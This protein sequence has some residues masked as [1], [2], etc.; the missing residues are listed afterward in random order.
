M[1]SKSRTSTPKSLRYALA[2][3]QRPL[4]A[5]FLLVATACSLVVSTSGLTGRA[6]PVAD[7]G[8]FGDGA[9]SNEGS[10]DSGASYR[11]LVLSD[12]PIAYWR[13]G[14]DAGPTLRDE[15]PAANGAKVS[16]SVTLGAPGAIVGESDTAASFTAAGALE[17]ESP[18][19]FSGVQPWTFEV[20][21]R[22]GQPDDKFRHLMS[23]EGTSDAGRETFGVYYHSGDVIV[24]RWVDGAG[25]G[26]SATP[27]AA[28]RWYHFVGVYDGTQ[29]IAYLDGSKTDTTPDVRVQRAKPGVAF[30][31]GMKVLPSTGGL[32]G[33]LDEVAVY[34]KALPAAAI[35]RHY[36]IGAGK[37]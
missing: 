33:S 12:G 4:L 22:P 31:V 2:V 10:A 16:G 9:V 36:A 29:L 26:A 37:R 27:P 8:P 15:S 30:L 1:R 25:R 6:E 35:A 3:G 28:D 20:W 14:E 19:D 11:D 24:E 7:A 18:I 13:L 32:L 17:S 34:P 5:C 23:K 21:F